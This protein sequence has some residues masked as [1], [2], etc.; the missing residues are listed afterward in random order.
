MIHGRTVH[1][2][3]F[4]NNSYFFIIRGLHTPPSSHRENLHQ[5]TIFT[6]VSGGG[7]LMRQL[8]VR[9]VGYKQEDFM[10]TIVIIQAAIFPIS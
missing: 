10:L 3:K 4:S 7:Q 8:R 5:L 1:S 2:P 9:N 6:Q